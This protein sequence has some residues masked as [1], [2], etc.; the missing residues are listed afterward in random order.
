MTS[1]NHFKHIIPELQPV[2]RGFLPRK[3]PPQAISSGCKPCHALEARAL[4]SHQ[5]LPGIHCGTE[6]RGGF[7]AEVASYGNASSGH[8]NPWL[9]MAPQETKAPPNHAKHKVWSTQEACNQWQTKDPSP[10]KPRRTRSA[11]KSR[12][13]LVGFEPGFRTAPFTGCR[14]SSELCT[15]L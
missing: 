13:W 4:L 12:T 2:F 3:A 8:G 11:S 5:V 1:S 10:H 7:A 9:P 6:H 14:L 15:F